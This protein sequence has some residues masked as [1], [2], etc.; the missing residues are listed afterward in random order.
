M[1]LHGLPPTYRKKK[2]KLFV[3]E[4]THIEPVRKGQNYFKNS[5]PAI[6]KY[7]YNV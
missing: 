5:I 2:K 3:E 7:N 4:E 6:V 1:I